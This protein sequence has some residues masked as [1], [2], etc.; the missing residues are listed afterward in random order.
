ME[1]IKILKQYLRFFEG[2]KLSLFSLCLLS[3]LSAMM[4][5]PIPLLYAYLIDSVLP[6][7]N[8]KIFFLAVFLLLLLFLTKALSNYCLTF[9]G[10]QSKT[11]FLIKMRIYF[12][13]KIQ[14]FSYLKMHQYSATDLASRLTRDLDILDLF[15]PL[16]IALAFKEVLLITGILSV[17]FWMHPSF[18]LATILSI[19]FFYGFYYLRLSSLSKLSHHQL[20][21][22]TKLQSALN[23][24]FEA[25]REIKVF[26]AFKFFRKRA[27]GYIKNSQ[28]R[29][30]QLSI[31]DA[32]L[33]FFV[34]MFPLLG[35]LLLWG[36]GGFWVLKN[37]ISLGEIIAFSYA[38]N[39]LFEPISNLFRNISLF[40]LERAALQRL[41]SSL[42][43]KE[44]GFNCY[45]VPKPTVK[46]DL[47]FESL[48]FAY[49]NQ[50]FIFHQLDFHI[51]AGSLCAFV[52]ANG[53][54]KSTLF[55]LIMSLLKPNKGHI[56]LGDYCFSQV[57]PAWLCNQIAWV[58]QNVFLYQSTVFNNILMGRK[59]NP[60]SLFEICDFVGIS[61]LKKNSFSLYTPVF[62]KGQNLSGGQ[63]QKIALARALLQKPKILLLDE[64]SNHLDLF[65]KDQVRQKLLLA[66]QGITVLVNTHDPDFLSAVDTVYE[67]K[68][69]QIYLKETYLA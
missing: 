21:S 65:F 12:Y 3:C 20:H 27:L 54:G 16:G 62:S 46:Y 23:E 36:L 38:F 68:N 22:K 53:V 10:S 55:A 24:I 30:R 43:A 33:R 44:E 42:P 39:F 8:I 13:D 40:P 35:A 69:K 26:N 19:P 57:Q 9:I 64:P 25:N 52:G 17:M 51:K 61:A 56:Y 31:L 37:K 45:V 49:P 50:T 6:T 2:F 47:R 58:P 63:I 32:Q 59:I 15:L 18:T 11:R 28:Y 66:K 29:E 4:T 7:Q 5:L 60:E 1:K 34:S 48:S 67:I 41:F 14:G